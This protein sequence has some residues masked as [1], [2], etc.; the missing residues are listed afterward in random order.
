[1]PASKR[2]ALERQ[3]STDTAAPPA[4]DYG[5][6]ATPGGATGSGGGAPGP[7]VV[8]ARRR[9]WSALPIDLSQGG[10]WPFDGH[11]SCSNKFPCP[12]PVGT[13]NRYSNGVATV[14]FDSSFAIRQLRREHRITSLSSFPTT[15][16]G[17]VVA[18]Y[19]KTPIDLLVTQNRQTIADYDD[20]RRQLGLAKKE[21]EKQRKRAVE[22]IAIA[23]KIRQRADAADVELEQL[24]LQLAAADDNYKK[25]EQVARRV[26]VVELIRP[27]TELSLP[28]ASGEIKRYRLKEV[29]LSDSSSTSSSD[30]SS[31]SNS[32]GG[33]TKLARGDK[34]GEKDDDG[35]DGVRIIGE[36][37]N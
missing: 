30:S 20:A 35:S 25:L 6:P 14:V 29:R 27:A 12:D 26:P 4:V 18:P 2:A 9:H 22:Q 36:L 28:S 11:R 33:Q 8:A 10:D 37:Q 31:E 3:T 24:T 5:S 21:V 15:H 16:L 13:V 34:D 23:D 19:D 1:M 7:A 32:G 17:Y